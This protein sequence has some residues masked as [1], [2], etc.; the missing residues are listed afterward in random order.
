MHIYINTYGTYIHI[1]D[2]VFEFKIPTG[3]GQTIKKYF[4][5]QKITGIVI[6]N[7]S[8][9]STDA[10]VL[11]VK[12]QID[13]LV[14]DELGRPIGRFWHSRIGS[15]TKIRKH[16]LALTFSP[17]GTEF[18]K[19]WLTR[20][21]KNQYDFLQRLKKNRP[22][23]VEFIDNQANQI[24]AL[25]D[26]IRNIDDTRPIDTIADTLRGLEGTAGR[27]YF[28]TL[29]QL[30]TKQYQFSGRSMRPAKDQFNAFLNYAYGVLYSRVEKAL[31]I[32]GLDPYVGIM[33]RDDYNLKSLVLDFIEPYRIWA[34]ETVFK[35]FS[36][37]KINNSHTDKI[38][39]GFSLNKEGKQL[40]LQAL[41]KFI[42]EDKINYKA[43]R[44]TRSDILLLEAIQFA[45]QV[46]N[47][48]V[49][50]DFDITII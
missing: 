22:N 42:D 12:H 2:Q 39:G 3:D 20:K 32:A 9:I 6:T 8:A 16:Q 41:T 46:L 36:A 48:P 37:K 5:P 35:L 18:I 7:G 1:K 11:A 49:P 38:T 29:S 27:I 50:D 25:R 24:K 14:M 17:H 45:M 28:Q 13:I 34:D 26:K 10:I 21:L 4:A 44:R 30:L 43:K 19:Q 15:T 23:K 33:H 47:R 31:M 40:L